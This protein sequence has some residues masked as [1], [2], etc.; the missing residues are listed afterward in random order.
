VGPLATVVGRRALLKEIHVWTGLCLPVPFVLAL[1]GRWR[2]GFRRD[3][4]RLN[5]WDGDDRRWLKTLG[6]D[7]N[8]RLGKF[9][10]GQKLNA[11]FVAA[12]IILMLGTGAIM[13][14]YKPF[15]DDIRTGATFVHDWIFI[16]LVVV[17]IGHIAFALRD[18]D[19]LRSMLRGWVPGRWARRHH[20][21]W[22]DEV[23]GGPTPP[24]EAPPGGRAAATRV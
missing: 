15:A 6:R 2:A 3:V 24:Q 19:S 20:P 17:I 9:N 11:T 5:R 13:R 22:Y 10:P 1:A 23:S 4:T 12:A 7:P 21:K 16:A 18:P 8:V 14:W